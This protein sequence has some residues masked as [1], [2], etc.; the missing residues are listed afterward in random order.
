[1]KT[2]SVMFCKF[3]RE[4]K[5]GWESGIMINED[6]L[7]IDMEGKAVDKMVHDYHVTPSRGTMIVNAKKFE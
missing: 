5:S 1:M 7:I 2:L 6:T 3:K 4:K